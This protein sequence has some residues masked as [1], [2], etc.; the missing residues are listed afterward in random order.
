MKIR[1]SRNI[2][3]IAANPNRMYGNHAQI[4]DCSLK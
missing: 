2:A 4:A 3:K 1:Q